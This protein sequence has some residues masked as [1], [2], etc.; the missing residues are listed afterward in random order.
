MNPW[1]SGIRQ[2]DP[3]SPLLFD[4]ITI[5]LIYNVKSSKIELAIFLYVDNIL[6]CVLGRGGAGGAAYL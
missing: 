1:R 5:V 4:V 2:G 3:L 6:F